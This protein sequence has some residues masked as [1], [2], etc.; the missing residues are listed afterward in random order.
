MAAFF[1]KSYLFSGDGGVIS[2]QTESHT[3]SIISSMFY[4][5]TCSNHGGAIYFYSSN[6]SLKMI[7]ANTCSC[8]TDRVG[9]FAWIQASHLNIM[10]YLSVSYCSYTSLGYY[11]TMISAGFQNVGNIN[12]SM[13]KGNIYGAGICYST[14]S[15][16]SSSYCTFSDNKVNNGVSINIYQTSG[17]MIYTNIVN[18]NTPSLSSS[19]YGTIYKN[20][21]GA[22]IMNNCIFD[23]NQ[24]TLFSVREGFLEVSY[25]FISHTGKLS[26]LTP[27]SIAKNNSLTKTLTYQIQFFKSHYCNADIPNSLNTQIN[28]ALRS[29]LPFIDLAILILT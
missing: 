7:C 15:N 12:C 24:N 5:C 17:T 11:S 10:Q 29:F 14:S 19:N 1:S 27:V 20:G 13:N 23:N 26:K 21:G 4:N 9:N 28:Y 6:S 3:L 2:I 25:S 22:Y 8:G 16:S 18:N